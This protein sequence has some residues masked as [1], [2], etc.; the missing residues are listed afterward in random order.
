MITREDLVSTA[1][2][3]ITQGSGTQALLEAANTFLV[4]EF[5][6]N[7]PSTQ[8]AKPYKPYTS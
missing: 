4:A 8:Y 1:L 3:I 7:A 2:T 5:S 6:A